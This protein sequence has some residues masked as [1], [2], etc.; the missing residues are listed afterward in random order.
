MACYLI[1]GATGYTG[2]R[3]VTSLLAQGHSV[4]GL[5][6]DP[7]S[8]TA[9]ELAA[10]GMTVWHGDI[11]H[12]ESLQGVADG[13]DYVYNLTTPSLLNIPSAHNTLHTGNH[14]LIAACS[15]NRNIQAYVFSSNVAPY[16][17]AGAD[18]VFEDSPLAPD[19]PLGEQTIAAE[20]HI[21]GLVQQHQFPA[22]ILRVA[23]IYGP[24]R[25]FTDAAFHRS[26][27]LFGNGNNYVPRIHVADL[28]HILELVAAYGQRG[29]VY[30]VGDNHPARLLTFYRD[31][32]N[33]LGI[34]TPPRISRLAAITAGL[35]PN[36]VNMAAASVRLANDRLRHDMPVT[37]R[38]PS[39]RTWLD[40]QVPPI[41]ANVQ[42]PVTA[43][44]IIETAAW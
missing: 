10:H 23:N 44:P 30:N 16:G 32:E 4:R 40:E 14:N 6:P 15:R 2:A 41:A 8:A 34:S 19:C 13:V 27:L 28:V 20:Q 29:A 11:T 33:R 38:Y 35:H 12:P 9:Q 36:V 24:G 31:L 17:D 3:L 22:I 5:V 42:P 26:L 18:R 39:Y 7:D 1:A 43:D 21:I 37:L 25:D